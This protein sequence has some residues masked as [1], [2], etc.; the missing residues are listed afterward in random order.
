MTRPDATAIEGDRS[1][2]AS[3]EIP[4]SRTMTSLH[5]SLPHGEGA[6]EAE[7]VDGRSPQGTRS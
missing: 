2:A 1:V 5:D 7:E 4:S 6:V 3:K